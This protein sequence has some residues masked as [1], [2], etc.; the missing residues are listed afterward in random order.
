MGKIV[1]KK[2]QSQA[3]NAPALTLPSTDGAANAVLQTDGNATLSWTDAA[4]GLGAATKSYSIPNTD[5]SANQALQVGT[6]SGTVYPTTFVTPGTNPFTTPDGNKQGLRLVDKYFFGLNDGANAASVDLIVPASM[7]TDPDDVLYFY[8][9][10]SGVSTVNSSNSMQIEV[11]PITQGGAYTR[12][13]GT[14]QSGISY[15]SHS[16]N[17]QNSG[18]TG[19]NPAY[20]N[21]SRNK[22]YFNATRWP[23]NAT[24]TTN[25]PSQQIEFWFWNAGAFPFLT[26]EGSYNDYGQGNYNGGLIAG[27]WANISSTEYSD[28]TSATAN[29]GLGLR[30]R[31]TTNDNI[32]DGVLCLYAHFRNGVVS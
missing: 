11:N 21:G 12:N 10:W 27:Q 15:M 16:G 29:H 18:L 28:S 31:Y 19:G 6:L 20:L 17:Y 32:R 9:T 5:G 22:P 8:M 25:V 13:G 2:I 14:N 1:V 3:N 4:Q 30:V 23:G 24:Q 26:A 7:T